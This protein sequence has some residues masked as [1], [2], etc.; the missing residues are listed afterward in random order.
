LGGCPEQLAVNIAV[1][2]TGHKLSDKF[3]VAV[4][5]LNQPQQHFTVDL[6]RAVNHARH[7]VTF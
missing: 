3:A 7:D 1:D 2:N 5:D 4:N 6:R